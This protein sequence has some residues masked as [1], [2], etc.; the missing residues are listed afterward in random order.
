MISVPRLRSA[1][2][3]SSGAS[4]RWTRF[5][6]SVRTHEDGHGESDLVAARDL[7]RELGPMSAVGQGAS[8]R[9]AEALAARALV[10]LASRTIGDSGL[11]DRAAAA[12]R[13]YDAANRYGRSQGAVLDTAIT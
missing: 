7:A 9:A 1:S 8:Q 13:T 5:A 2:A 10:A 3:L 12:A 6:A 4:R 11:R